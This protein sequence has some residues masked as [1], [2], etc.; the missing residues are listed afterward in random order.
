MTAKE[1]NLNASVSRE[2][3]AARILGSFIDAVAQV[4][5]FED[6]ATRLRKTVI[7]DR[8]LTEVALREALF[9]K[10]P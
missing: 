6:V 8:Q 5:G 9:G 2:S 7:E 3:V 1:N 10:T 4:D